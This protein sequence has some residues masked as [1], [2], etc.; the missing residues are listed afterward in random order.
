MICLQ[1]TWL[2]TGGTF[3]D[4]PGYT[5]LEHR[6]PKGKRGGIAL[7]V[8]KGL[9][10]TLVHTCEYAQVLKLGLPDHQEAFVVNTYLPPVA[11]LSRKGVTPDQL[12]AIMGDVMSRLPHTATLL[13]CGDF[14][15]RTGALLGPAGDPPPR[16]RPTQDSHICPRGRWLATQWGIWG[17]QPL[18][19]HYRDTE[20]ASTCH[21]ANGSSVVDY[22]CT[23]A[24]VS[25]FTTCKMISQGI[26][27]HSPLWCKLAL[28]S[29]PTPPPTPPASQPASF[30]YQWVEGTHITN[31]SASWRTWE[32][33]GNN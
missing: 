2:P 6:R 25:D 1:E 32:D 22:I 27:D 3:P 17:C 20:G 8:K 15:A 4:I 24:P 14:N 12:D 30:M 19:G 10:W 7:L 13:L 26:S 23:R 18:N 5:V 33:H 31:Y 28:S 29:S 16:P 9:N 21:R 11:S